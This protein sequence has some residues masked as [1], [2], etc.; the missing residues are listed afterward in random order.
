MS[1]HLVPGLSFDEDRLAARRQTLGASEIAA[2]AGLNPKKTA[3]DVFLEKRGLVPAFAGNAFTEWGLRLEE[4]IAQKYAEVTGFAVAPSD[5]VVAEWMSCTPDRLVNGGEHGLEIKRFG[6]YRADEFGV[7]GTDEIPFDVATQCHW[8]MLVTGLRRW[9]LAVLLGQADFRIYTLLFNESIANDLYGIGREFWFNHV[10][11]GVQ[12]AIDGSESSRRFLKQ[13]YPTHGPSLVDATPELVAEARTLADLR[14]EQKH[15]EQQIT[16]SENRLKAA[17][18][19]N[20]G[21]RGICS[22]KLERSG[23]P[24]WKDIAEKLGA[25]KP[26]HAKLVEQFTSAPSRRFLFTYK[27]D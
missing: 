21:I 8:S 24:R 22:W 13:R 16:A 19:E 20:A 2:V 9:D 23:R 27:E 11:P 17:I 26:E 18:G 1:T 15:I 5:T 3:L 25:T 4:P 14:E 7:P 10:V 12:P 6:D